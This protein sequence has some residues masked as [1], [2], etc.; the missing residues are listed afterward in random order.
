MPKSKCSGCYFLSENIYTQKLHCQRHN[1]ERQ[2]DSEQV[3]VTKI[4]G[5]SELCDFQPIVNNE[6]KEA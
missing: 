3:F 4:D 6:R 1:I 5:G 2:K